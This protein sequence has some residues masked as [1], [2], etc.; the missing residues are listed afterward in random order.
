MTWNLVREAIIWIV[1][2][3]N[4]REPIA[5]IMESMFDA[6]NHS[7][8]LAHVICHLTETTSKKRNPAVVCALTLAKLDS[9][10]IL[11]LTVFFFPI[12]VNIQ[13]KL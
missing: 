6:A 7:N 9:I 11:K 3:E 10:I 8:A 5:L 13:C 4:G 12:E 2:Q 1:Y